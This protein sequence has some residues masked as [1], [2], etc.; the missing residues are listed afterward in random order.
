[1]SDSQKTD[2]GMSDSQKNDRSWLWVLLLVAVL[3]ALYLP[4][5]GEPDHRAAIAERTPVLQALFS[6]SEFFGGAE[7]K[8]HDWYFFSFMTARFGNDRSEIPISLGVLGKI[9]YLKDR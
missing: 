4:K 1:M 3:G 7:M 8:Y 5:P 6:V 2:S 9:F